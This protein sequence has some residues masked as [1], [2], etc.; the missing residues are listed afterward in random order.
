M[1]TTDAPLI[2]RL[3]DLPDFDHAVRATLAV[4]RLRHIAAAQLR[5]EDREQATAELYAAHEPIPEF[6]ATAEVP[7]QEWTDRMLQIGVLVELYVP[8]AERPRRRGLRL[9][10]GGA[11]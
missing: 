10:R 11:R 8:P 1:Q 4:Q 2:V 6:T 5:V 7:M 9:L 3:R